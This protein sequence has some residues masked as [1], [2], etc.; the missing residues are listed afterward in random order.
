MLTISQLSH[1]WKLIL[2]KSPLQLFWQNGSKTAFG[3]KHKLLPLTRPRSSRLE[4]IV[5]EI[6]V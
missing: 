2:I 6:H 1:F 4:D 5:I 3:P